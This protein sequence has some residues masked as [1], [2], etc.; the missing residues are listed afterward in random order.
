LELLS[1][2]DLRLLMETE[3]ELRE[4]KWY[5]DNASSFFNLSF[6]VRHLL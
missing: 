5:D 6:D 1:A 4:A 2:D 3:D